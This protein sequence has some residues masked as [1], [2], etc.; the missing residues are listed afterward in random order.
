[1]YYALYN[2]CTILYTVHM[3]TVTQ[4]VRIDPRH[5]M[6]GIHPMICLHWGGLEGQCRHYVAYMEGLGIN[7]PL[8]VAT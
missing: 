8:F 6:Y 1:M 5:S 2:K 4:I 7:A 3:Y